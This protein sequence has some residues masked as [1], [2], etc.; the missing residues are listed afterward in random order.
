MSPSPKATLAS[1][2]PTFFPEEQIAQKVSRSGEGQL[3]TEPGRPQDTSF[4]PSPNPK[5]TL[6]HKVSPGKHSDWVEGGR[7]GW[8][9]GSLFCLGLKSQKLTTGRNCPAW[10]QAASPSH[11]RS[12]L[13]PHKPTAIL[14][15]T[16]QPGP[17][18]GGG[19]CSST[20]D[21]LPAWVSHS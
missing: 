10:P 15:C 18:K 16:P 8:R 9:E 13:T 11:R 17:A 5:P 3:L 1:G 7:R 2:M 20:P 14:T 4:L 12:R 19:P 21:F 6:T